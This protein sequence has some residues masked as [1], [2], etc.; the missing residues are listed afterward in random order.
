M[1]PRRLGDVTWT[2]PLT[3]RGGA[4]GRWRREEARPILRQE[5]AI[6]S[7]RYRVVPDFETGPVLCGPCFHAAQGARLVGVVIPEHLSG[8]RVGFEMQQIRMEPRERC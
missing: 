8:S 3:Y 7:Y 6:G 2:S 1:S 4:G 5:R